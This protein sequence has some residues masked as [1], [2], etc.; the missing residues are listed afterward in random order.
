MVTQLS[1]ENVNIVASQRVGNKKIQCQVRGEHT[2]DKGN[3]LECLSRGDT[4]VNGNK[5]AYNLRNRMANK[6]D[7]MSKDD[8]KELL[9]N[10]CNKYI[11][12]FNS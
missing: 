6:A 11:E 3:D 4:Q 8:V 10:I 2:E 1:E 9:E 7:S 12:G 5:S